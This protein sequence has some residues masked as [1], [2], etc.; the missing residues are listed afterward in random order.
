[1]HALMKNM[2]KVINQVQ[3]IKLR[4]PFIILQ[5]LLSQMSSQRIYTSTVYFLNFSRQVYLR[6]LVQ[7]YICYG[8]TYT[9][10]ISIQFD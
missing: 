8:P 7:T 9:T 1:M 2:N 6:N 10:I 3:F 4:I 5:L